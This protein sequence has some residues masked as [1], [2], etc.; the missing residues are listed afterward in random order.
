M[1]KTQRSRPKT[2]WGSIKV[3]L[4]N[5]LRNELWL[6]RLAI[7]LPGL[8]CWI[9]VVGT[10]PL[11]AQ[12]TLESDLTR[13][14]P[15]DLAKSA[16]ILG[17]ASRGAIIF[18]RQGLSCTQCHTAGDGAKL[19]GPDLS[20]Q[21]ERATYEHVIE[22]ILEPSKVIREGYRME[23]LLVDGKV[24]SA[25]VRKETDAQL[26]VVVPGE[27]KPRTIAVDDIEERVPS[28]S[29]MSDGL[30]NQLSDESE[31]FDLVKF[32]VKLGEGGPKLADRLKPD[33]DLIAAK[34]L[35]E[36]EALLTMRG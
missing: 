25:V 16:R 27:E 34:P 35:P 11:R 14:H 7:S 33:A 21:R 12:A 22:S 4:P 23:N 20:Q 10:I 13:R 9:L 15:A 29:V 28:L 18:H 30:I 19:L 2:F 36:Y 32:L 24:V 17:D 5:A 6:C 31:F 26:V 3:R 8:A 1:T